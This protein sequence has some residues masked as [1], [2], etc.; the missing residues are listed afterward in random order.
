MPKPNVLCISLHQKTAFYRRGHLGAPG[1]AVATRSWPALRR[2][3]RE[4]KQALHPWRSRS[5]RLTTSGFES[6]SHRFPCMIQTPSR[7][8]EPQPPVSC[9]IQTQSPFR[10]PQSPVSMHEPNPIP[11]REPQ[12]PVSVH[13]PN[14]IPVSRASATG[15]RV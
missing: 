6:L 5:Q 7:F 4:L 11:F 14:L 13:D 10:E 1:R 8:R 2:Q 3:A 12:P 15:F 9:M